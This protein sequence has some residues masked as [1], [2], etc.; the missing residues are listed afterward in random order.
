MAEFVTVEVHNEFARRID[1]E[2]NRVSHRLST[3]EESVRQITELV[4]SVKV[5]ATQMEAMATEQR[6]M[7]DRLDAIEEKPAKRW[8][9]VISGIISGVIGILIGL[10]SAGIIK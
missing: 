10:V 2:N 8:D 3:L 4:A 1:D 6:K 7:G 9:T 5:L